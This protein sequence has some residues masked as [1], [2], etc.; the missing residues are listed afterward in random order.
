[1]ICICTHFSLL[2]TTALQGLPPI[3]M[4][5]STIDELQLIA[6]FVILQ[7]PAQRLRL[8]GSPCQGDLRRPY[9]TT[10]LAA[11]PRSIWTP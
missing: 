11:K 5:G 1:M 10:Y 2:A 4:Q 7:I 8:T 6:F 3:P 9:S